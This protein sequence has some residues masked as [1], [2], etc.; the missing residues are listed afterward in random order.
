[1]PW[2]IDGL[3][4]PV[5]PDGARYGAGHDVG[6]GFGRMHRTRPPA[7]MVPLR[8]RGCRSKRAREDTLS[9]HPTATATSADPAD[10]GDDPLDL[11]DFYRRM[12]HGGHKT[13]TG[14]RY[15]RIAEQLEDRPRR[16]QGPPLDVLAMIDGIQAVSVV[17]RRQHRDVLLV[18]VAAG[19]VGAAG[20]LQCLQ[21]RLVCVC[22]WLDADTV[23][24][25]DAKVPVVALGEEAPWDLAMAARDWV[26]QAR[27]DAETA[28]LATAP[29]PELG[30]FLVLD[31]ALPPDGARSDVVGVIKTATDT[32]WVMDP[33][34]LPD[35]EGF[36]SPA[37]R[38]PGQRRGERARLTCYVRLRECDPQQ[39]WG[40]SLVRAEVYEDVGIAALDRLAARMMVERQPLG[41]GDPRAEIQMASMYTTEQVLKARIPVPFTFG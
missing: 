20:K 3:P 41:S 21:E 1:L 15:R 35:R 34:L 37:L 25:A 24:Q 26:D 11:R 32:D 13:Q 17:T 10:G 4:A 7:Q 19:A 30:A 36:R 23:H 6:T 2:P 8:D 22:S 39:P 38:L 9:L 28:A 5:L 27:R 14:G 29:A 18:Y 12:G 33:R 31:G 40:F 16:I